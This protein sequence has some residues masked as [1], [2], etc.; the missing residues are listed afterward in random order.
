M[1]SLLTLNRC[2][3]RSRNLDVT[4]S[5]E[6]LIFP[7]LNNIKP[8]LDLGY[9]CIE[10]DTEERDELDLI[11]I[12]LD[13]N[14]TGKELI[15]DIESLLLSSIQLKN[16]KNASN[17]Y[18]QNVISRM[19]QNDVFY[20]VVTL[21]IDI[22][23]LK[24]R[25]NS[26]SEE[27][28]EK[29]VNLLKPLIIKLI[30]DDFENFISFIIPVLERHLKCINAKS[31]EVNSPT[32]Y[33][34]FFNS[35]ILFIFFEFSKFTLDQLNNGLIDNRLDVFSNIY[36][37]L[38]DLLTTIII[39]EFSTSLYIYLL[40]L[41]S[42]IFKAINYKVIITLDYNNDKSRY[43]N[44]FF[45]Y[46]DISSQLVEI[47]SISKSVL[48]EEIT[49]EKFGIFYNKYVLFNNENKMETVLDI[50]ET[51]YNLTYVQEHNAYIFQ[52]CIKLL[53]ISFIIDD[54]N[55]RLKKYIYYYL[56]SIDNDFFINNVNN[57][58]S[59]TNW[60]NQH[61]SDE[62][63]LMYYYNILRYLI[64]YM[65]SSSI[66]SKSLISFNFIGLINYLD[67]FHYISRKDIIPI[68]DE[69]L[70]TLSV[71]NSQSILALINYSSQNKLNLSFVNSKHENEIVFKLIKSLFRVSLL[72][73]RDIVT[74]D[75]LKDVFW[76]FTDI[77][78]ISLIG[79]GTEENYILCFNK[80]KF[81]ILKLG[82]HL[83][84]DYLYHFKENN[85]ENNEIDTINR[86]IT[87]LDTLLIR[88]LILIEKIVNVTIDASFRNQ[89]FQIVFDV[90]LEHLSAIK[91]INS[92]NI[93]IKLES[94]EKL[95]SI[96][97]EINDNKVNLDL[98]MIMINQFDIILLS[99]NSIK[100]DY[101]Y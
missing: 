40:T 13:N 55:I 72:Y 99:L 36:L 41:I 67:I 57:N 37:Q 54:N 95:K 60:D 88:L 30:N 93:H 92:L 71:V 48:Y 43:L 87:D 73:F 3:D 101:L 17:D 33:A 29:I 83:L 100:K 25:E 28:V 51:I 78:H 6:K 26:C 69:K 74:I 63:K 96:T 24:L 11:R 81:N 49:A 68:N 4:Y 89:I 65:N 15:L 14:Y 79:D 23:M 32:N 52:M 19:I 86:F 10:N 75:L 90:I 21:Y 70:N 82:F 85:T 59:I 94:I 1:D 66:S 5:D 47:I 61:L 45:N 2:L 64:D 97:N 62:L 9:K 12:E 22:Y 80:V 8:L 35:V 98:S 34:K 27:D 38:I 31:D 18:N 42:E 39:P 77:D 76:K 20:K 53:D 46:I 84:R 56:K 50:I 16:D 44:C 91:L 7:L 58:K